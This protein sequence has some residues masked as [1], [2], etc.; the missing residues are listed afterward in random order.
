MLLFYVIAI[1][2]TA[3][4]R[5]GR[6][7]W[8]VLWISI[9]AHLGIGWYRDREPFVEML[10]ITITVSG[11][12]LGVSLLQW[13]FS[14]QL[15]QAL[16]SARAYAAVLQEYRDHLE[17][18]IKRRTAA[19]RGANEEL[20][21]E[22]SERRHAQ[23]ALR[24]AHDELETRVAERTTELTIMLDAA[25]A[26]SS[27]LDLDVVLSEIAKQMV[28]AIMVTDCIIAKFDEETNSI[29]SWAEWRR[30]RTPRAEKIDPSLPLSNLPTFREVLDQRQPRT[31]KISDT[32][33]TSG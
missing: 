14:N 5:G 7:Q 8:I 9:I 33:G 29:V 31:R 4:L 6:S 13:F 1:L 17:E 15:E 18:L 26:V 25:R 32:D 27:T 28:L 10:P 30:L 22:I 16:T 11:S 24:K 23:E 3:V 12:L 19:L 2:L 21:K 20:E